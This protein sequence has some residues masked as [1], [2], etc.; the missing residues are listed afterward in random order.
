MT[1]RVDAHDTML[2]AMARIA[3]SHGVSS[4]VESYWQMR[5]SGLSD[6]RLRMGRA[7]ILMRAS[8]DRA[9]ASYSEPRGPSPFL[10]ARRDVQQGAI[11]KQYSKTRGKSA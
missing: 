4:K 2:V 6:L 11:F 10:F 9:N 8:A 1:V 5:K 7:L 3:P